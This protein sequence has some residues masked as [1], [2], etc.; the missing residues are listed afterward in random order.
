MTRRTIAFGAWLAAWTT[1]LAATGAA[2]SPPGDAKR[3]EDV[4]S[5]CMGCHSL[6]YNRIGP[7]HCGVI[8]RKAGSVPGFDYSD[9]MK[10]SGIVWTPEMLDKFLKKPTAFVPGTIMTFD[11][12]P[13][14]PER[15]DVIAY[16]EMANKSKELCP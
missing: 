4:Y 15:A 10:K 3:G 12:V 1:L 16:L 5:R 6:D 7:K 11:G 2:A 8:G 13:D 14:D 9:A